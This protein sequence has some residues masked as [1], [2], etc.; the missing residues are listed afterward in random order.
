MK[1][2][3]TMPTRRKSVVLLCIALALCAAFFPAVSDLVW[4]ELTAQWVLL[5]D[6]SIV[7]VRRLATIPASEQPLA[8]LSVSGSRGPPPLKH[9]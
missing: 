4:P 1:V 7:A 6:T 8:L 9:N 3:F 5:P 2:S